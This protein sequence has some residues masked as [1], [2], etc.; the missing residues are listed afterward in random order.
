MRA[1]RISAV[2]PAGRKMRRDNHYDDDRDYG[3]DYW[4]ATGGD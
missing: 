4:G 2:G 1:R 3:R